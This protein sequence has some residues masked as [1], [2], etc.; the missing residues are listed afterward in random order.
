[1]II[2]M[3]VVVVNISTHINYLKSVSVQVQVNKHASVLLNIA[4]NILYNISVV[5]AMWLICKHPQVFFLIS[6]QYR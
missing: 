5:C 3:I 2:T 4:L 6:V 1:M